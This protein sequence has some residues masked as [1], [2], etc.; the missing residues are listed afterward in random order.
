[1]KKLIN[2]D[3]EYEWANMTG[4]YDNPKDYKRMCK[5]C[6]HKQDIDSHKKD[7]SGRFINSVGGGSL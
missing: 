6:H 3:K 2:L 1:M 7:I 5:K 4:D